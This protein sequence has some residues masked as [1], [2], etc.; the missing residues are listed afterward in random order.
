MFIGGLQKFTLLDYPGKIAA[1][2]FT[3]GCNFRCPFC[4][5]PE[6]VDP[7]QIDYDKGIEEKEVLKFLESR[8][9]NLDGICITG[10]EPTLQIGLA[11]FIGK[12]KEMGFKIKLD[13][14]AS[15]SKAVENLIDNELVDYWAV[16]IKTIPIKYKIIT[17]RPDAIKNIEKSI[18]LISQSGK[19]LELRTTVVP[20]IVTESDIDG[21]IQWLDGINEGILPSLC[22]YSIQEFRPGKTLNVVYGKVNP[23]DKD[24]LEKMAEKLRKRCKNVVVNAR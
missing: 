10:G 15:N 18:S 14:N 1:V 20:G 19:D 2:V 5:N 21:I 9:N 3:T 12:V 7:K 4:H 6:I 13:T 24:K 17:N 11:D 22:R 8:I 16:D 23:Y